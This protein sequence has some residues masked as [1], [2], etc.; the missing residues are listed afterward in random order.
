MIPAL[1]LSDKVMLCAWRHSGCSCFRVV[2]SDKIIRGRDQWLILLKEVKRQPVFRN[3]HG[4]VAFYIVSTYSPVAMRYERRASRLTRRT[5]AQEEGKH[6]E[7][8]EIIGVEHLSGPV[9]RH[10]LR[11]SRRH[12]RMIYRQIASL[13]ALMPAL[14]IDKTQA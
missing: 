8:K 7:T 2:G 11:R 1:I 5:E 14:G 10:I 12:I 6:G 13:I 4:A 3:L 9:S